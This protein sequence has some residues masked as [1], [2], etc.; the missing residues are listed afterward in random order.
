[1]FGVEDY[2]DGI[3]VVCHAL[4]GCGSRKQNSGTVF[5]Y[6]FFAFRCHVVLG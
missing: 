6:H 3:F 2:D 1:M 4:V 5:F